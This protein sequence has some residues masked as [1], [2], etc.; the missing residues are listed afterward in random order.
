MKVTK[1][2]AQAN[3]ARLIAAASTLFREHGYDGAG[4][5]DISAAAG[6]TQGA[7]YRH[8]PSKSDL[9]AQASAFGISKMV[10]S[11]HGED[12]AGFFRRYVSR[13]HRDARG[14]GCTMA[15]LCGDASRQVEDVKTV[16]ASG[17]E[18]LLTALA[19]EENSLK[20]SD[21]RVLRTE[22]IH[23]LAQAVGAVTLSRACPD[24]SPLADEIL[25]VC[26]RQIMAE[27]R[28]SETA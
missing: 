2:Q 14:T 5:A 21:R 26:R 20:L 15:S 16:F 27:L 7:L 19:L 3:R 18:M 4:V 25:G 22:L 24:D 28:P 23:A 10:E 9:M 17:I 11:T 6:F 1:S 12:V 13:S 8:F